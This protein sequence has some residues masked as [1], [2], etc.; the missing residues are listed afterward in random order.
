MSHRFCVEYECQPMAFECFSGLHYVSKWRR[1]KALLRHCRKHN[2][3]Y[4]INR[5]R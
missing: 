1:L 5:Y 3:R 4:T 2:L